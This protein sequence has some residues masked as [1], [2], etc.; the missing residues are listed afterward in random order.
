MKM[1]MYKK[2]LQKKEEELEDLSNSIKPGTTPF[3][4]N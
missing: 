1:F 4:L 2:K 3:F